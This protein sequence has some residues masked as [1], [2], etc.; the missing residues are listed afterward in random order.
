[1]TRRVETSSVQSTPETRCG[2]FLFK[3]FFCASG[4]AFR[5]PHVLKKS[6]E[7]FFPVDGTFEF[8]YLSIDLV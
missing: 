7:V 2:N 1:M 8:I 3:T 4:S 5:Q 6:S